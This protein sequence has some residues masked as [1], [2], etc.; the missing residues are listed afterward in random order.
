MSANNPPL[1]PQRCARCA[2]PMKL[3]RRTQRFGGLPDLCTF[4]CL[5]CGMSHTEE[6]RPPPWHAADVYREQA[7]ACRELA[8][9]ARREDRK[10]W[11]HLS[12]G[13]LK[14]AQEAD[15]RVS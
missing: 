6:C 10:F 5:A 2:Q 15:E 3:I 13:W 14:L 7:K 9:Q 12:D 1:V 4:E 11:L 8:T